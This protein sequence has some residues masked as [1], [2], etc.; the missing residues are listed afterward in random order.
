VIQTCLA[1]VSSPASFIPWAEAVPDQ[2][3]S[4]TKAIAKMLF[5]VLLP[6]CVSA[7][8]GKRSVEQFPGVCSIEAPDDNQF[9]KLWFKIA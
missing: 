8:R 5:I 4:D 2:L 3:K 6:G 9:Q 1:F 7:Y